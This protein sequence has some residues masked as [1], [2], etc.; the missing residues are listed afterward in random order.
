MIKKIGLFFCCL[1]FVGCASAKYK[2]KDGEQFTYNRFGSM[3]IAGLE[4]ERDA[5]GI[6]KIKIK[7]SQGDLGQLGEVI[8]DLAEKAAQAKTP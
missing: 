7:S 5:N 8:S 1:V 2:T 4:F 3:N 6:K